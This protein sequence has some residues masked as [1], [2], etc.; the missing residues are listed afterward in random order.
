LQIQGSCDCR[1]TLSEVHE[2][3]SDSDH[4]FSDDNL[5]DKSSVEG[6]YQHLVPGNGV[7]CVM[8]QEHPARLCFPSSSSM[9]TLGGSPCT[10]PTGSA[11]E[12][13]SSNAPVCGHLGERFHACPQSN[14]SSAVVPLRLSCHLRAWDF[15]FTTI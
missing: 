10:D 12:V 7:L 2:E 13:P 1:Y 14:D 11:V 3:Y 6:C 8:E 9:H 4:D 5:S 15:F